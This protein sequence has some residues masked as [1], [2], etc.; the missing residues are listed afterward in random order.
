[1]RPAEVDYLKGDATK[2]ENELG[3]RRKTSFPALV[4]KMVDNDVNLL[5]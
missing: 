4:A 2:A 5:K 1:M 3:W